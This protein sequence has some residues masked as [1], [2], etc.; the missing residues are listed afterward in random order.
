MV[1]AWKVSS[2]RRKPSPMLSKDL[3]PSPSISPRSLRV[4]RIALQWQRLI[5]TDP[6]KA[7]LLLDWNE[8]FLQ[9]KNG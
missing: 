4:Q 2:L 3:P 6:V 1:L 9:L 8:Q 7:D 5:E